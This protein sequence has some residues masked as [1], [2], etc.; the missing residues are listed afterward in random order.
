[1]QVDEE[2]EET[3]PE[4]VDDVVEE[5]QSAVRPTKE[6]RHQMT[7]PSHTRSNNQMSR[8]DEERGNLSQKTR[9]TFRKV[10]W[11]KSQQCLV[12][13]EKNTLNDSP[14]KLLQPRSK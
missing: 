14:I 7:L 13:L 11:A 3:V 4:P 12:K 9:E 2:E 5:E 1:M 6:N 8:T 10:L